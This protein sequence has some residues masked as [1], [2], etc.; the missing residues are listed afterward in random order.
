MKKHLSHTGSALLGFAEGGFVSVIPLPLNL[1]FILLFLLLW[2]ILH[3]RSA[4]PAERL[5]Y[6]IKIGVGVLTVVIAILLPFKL[7]DAEIGPMKYERM[8]LYELSQHLRDDWHFPMR[9][10]DPGATNT[11]LTFRIGKPASRRFVL[12]KLAKETNR[13]LKLVFVGTGSPSTFLL[14]M[15]P[16][17]IYLEPQKEEQLPDVGVRKAT[18]EE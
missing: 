1:G 15:N 2:P 10:S 7:L 14:G 12:E 6:F 9:V 8:S 3:A 16:T 13:E 17:I 5:G 11:F 18:N 4:T